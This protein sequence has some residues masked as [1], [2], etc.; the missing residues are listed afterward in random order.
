MVVRR[1]GFAIFLFPRDM[2][3]ITRKQF[4]KRVTSFAFYQGN[5]DDIELLSSVW[6]KLV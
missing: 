5:P 1:R 6:C 4:E 3:E 2:E